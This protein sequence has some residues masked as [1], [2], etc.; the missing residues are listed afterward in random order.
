MTDSE[1]ENV[2]LEIIRFVGNLCHLCEKAPL[3]LESLQPCIPAPMQLASQ[4]QYTD[5]YTAPPFR[6]SATET[7]TELDARIVSGD[8]RRVGLL[9][10]DISGSE[11]TAEDV[12]EHFPSLVVS[13]MPRGDSIHEKIYYRALVP[14][15]KLSFG[16]N[17]MFPHYLNSIVFDPA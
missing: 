10:L 11:L 3:T 6:I 4:N 13:A 14:W 7:V 5:F 15:G 12:K 9:A 16:F 1:Y 8:R 17:Q 2:E